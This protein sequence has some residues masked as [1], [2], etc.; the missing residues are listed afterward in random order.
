[1]ELDEDAA[2]IEVEFSRLFAIAPLIPADGLP[3]VGASLRLQSTSPT[4]RAADLIGRRIYYAFESVEASRSIANEI[5]RTEATSDERKIVD[6][7]Q[8]RRLRYENP[9]VFELGVPAVVMAILSVGWFISKTG[10][11][12]AD[13]YK[14]VQEAGVDKATAKKI[15]AE[16]K[17]V[18]AETEGLSL[19][20]VA[21][22]EE[23]LTTALLFKVGRQALEQYLEPSDEFRPS[24][25]DESRRRTLAQEM[26]GSVESL[27]QQGVDDL[28]VDTD[29]PD[30]N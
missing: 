10:G 18:E 13:I 14:V 11:K 6:V 4:D 24:E 1:M 12:F 16:A 26:L 20:N 29:V 30:Q 22:R 2:L 7:P 3:I 8:I 23:A 28:D 15:E 19:D 17:R 25:L 27:Q 21:K 9:L 5:L